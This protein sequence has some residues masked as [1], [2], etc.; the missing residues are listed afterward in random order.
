MAKLFLKGLK[1]AIIFSV[2]II[3]SNSVKAQM[4]CRSM[5]GAHLTPFKKNIPILWAIEG[6]MAPG[7]MTSPFT[8]SENTTLNGGMVLAALDFTILKKHNIYIE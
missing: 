6:T 1:L 5:L 8:D 3:T 7:I 4:E 2:I